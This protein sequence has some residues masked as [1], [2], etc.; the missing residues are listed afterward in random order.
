MSRTIPSP[1]SPKKGM[2]KQIQQIQQ[3]Q[4]I[5]P[6]SKQWLDSAQFLDRGQGWLW[7][8]ANLG[9][10]NILEQY[11]SHFPSHAFN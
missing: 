5:Q 6:V 4:R 2:I 10:V 1:T 8:I 3:I 9:M 7:L 11:H